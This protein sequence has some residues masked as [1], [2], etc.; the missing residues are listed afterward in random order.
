MKVSASL[1]GYRGPRWTPRAREAG[2]TEA[3]KG[4]RVREGMRTGSENKSGRG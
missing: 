2:V 4:K 1:Q 3:G